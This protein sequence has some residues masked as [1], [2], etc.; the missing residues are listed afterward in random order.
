[1]MWWASSVPSGLGGA[2]NP[3]RDFARDYA[4]ALLTDLGVPAAFLPAGP[5]EHPA[6]G[7]ASSGA[8]AMTG[9][10]DRPPVMCPAPLAACADGALMALALCAGRDFA[11]IPS[12]ARLLGERAAIAGTGRSPLAEAAGS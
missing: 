1:L 2:M 9:Y 3:G 7:W 5:A 4:S 6:I 8:M 12:G 11:A 10:R